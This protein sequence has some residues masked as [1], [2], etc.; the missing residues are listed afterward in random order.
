[1]TRLGLLPLSIFLLTGCSGPASPTT[2][3]APEST[4]KSLASPLTTLS[5][6]RGARHTWESRGIGGGGA[7]YGPTISPFDP[8]EIYMGTDMITLFHTK[9]FGKEWFAEPFQVVEGQGPSTSIQWTSNPDVLFGINNG[10]GDNS[11]LTKSTDA[12]RSWTTLIPSTD[13]IYYLS[14]DQASAGRF[15]VT[16]T[17]DLYFSADGGATFST[18]YTTTSG[19]GL[20]MGGAFWR[21]ADVFVGTSDGLLVSHDGG[22]TFALEAL[23]GIPLGESIVSFSGARQGSVTRFFAV[24][25][26]G[27]YAGM[28]GGDFGGYGATYSL[29][30]GDVAWTPLAVGLATDDALSFVATSLN[31]VNVAYVAGGNQDTG[32]DI[33]FKTTDG[34]KTWNRCLLT[35]NNANIATGWAGAGGWAGLD[36][37]G[38]VLGFTVSPTDSSRAVMTD[39]GAVHVTTN[40]AATWEAAYVAPK[41]LTPPGQLTPLDKAVSSNGVENT[42]VWYMT[43]ASPE[44]IFS[45]ITDVRGVWTGDGGH[46]WTRAGDDGLTLNTTYHAIKS[47]TSGALYAG[48]S[49]QHDIYESTTLTDDQIDSATGAIMVSKDDGAHFQTLEDIGHPVIFLALDPNHTNLLYA[50]VVNSEVGGIYRKD[51]SAPQQPAVRLAAPP[52][53][54]GHPYNLWVLNDGSL[55][56]SYSAHRLGT[57]GNRGPFTPSSGVFLSTDGGA[58]WSD[59]SDPQMQYWTKDVVIDPHDLTQSTWYAGVFTHAGESSSGGLYRTTN[60]GRTWTKLAGPFNVESLTVHP[61]DPNVAYYT[62]ETLGLFVTHDLRAAQPTFTPVA[63]YPFRQPLRVFFN[64]YDHAETW[65]TSFGGGMR[66]MHE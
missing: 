10:P 60:R 63:E 21:G 12:G 18:V 30:D 47:P 65:V 37:T 17:N 55:L 4:G 36:W 22:A 6:A 66:V 25:S 41:D 49:L 15:L 35:D 1:M 61:D 64:P 53:T 24:T 7:L 8:D 5:A 3:D 46:T 43:W 27:P 38:N 2:N 40:G 23:G 32:F 11:I 54:S 51:L 52:R 45:S 28:T 42:S 48:T 56:A 59:R 31:D 58:T 9:S 33:V 34:G 50:S 16:D 62:T 13:S 20:V 29:T 44:K 19:N 26:T 57:R 39:Y 14:V